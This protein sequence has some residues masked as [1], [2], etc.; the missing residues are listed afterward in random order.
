MAT[1][2]IVQGIAPGSAPRRRAIVRL[3]PPAHRSH[4][5]L[6]RLAR[7][8]A[9]LALLA[10]LHAVAVFADESQQIRTRAGLRFFRTL[11]AADLGITGKTVDD[12]KLLLLVFY[13]TD[14]KQAEELATTLRGTT[15]GDQAIKGRTLVVETTSDPSL[16]LYA[17][18]RPAGIFLAQAPAADGLSALIRYGIDQRVIVYSPFEGHVER[19]VLG[20]ISIEAQVR[21]YINRATL[22]ASRISLKE[23]VVEASKVYR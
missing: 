13:V 17:G 14:R 5:A 11:L 7:S 9:V 23:L 4:F 2:P 8:L 16:R 18:R 20:G 10:T 21:P 15:A 3:R 22:E 6:R 12:G 1:R 19:G